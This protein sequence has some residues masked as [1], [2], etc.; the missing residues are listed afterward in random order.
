M[1]D[2]MY[3]MNYPSSLGMGSNSFSAL[4]SETD[5]RRIIQDEVTRMKE[6]KPFCDRYTG[7]WYNEKFCDSDDMAE[8]EED[9]LRKR[10][11]SCSTYTGANDL[12]QI[13]EGAEI[14]VSEI[15]L[16]NT[17][18]HIWNE[19]MY[20]HDIIAGDTTFTRYI[21]DAP[22]LSNVG[23]LGYGRY[24]EFVRYDM[25]RV[26]ENS[27]FINDKKTMFENLRNRYERIES[28][29]DGTY[30]PDGKTYFDDVVECDLKE[31]YKIYIKEWFFLREKFSSP[32]ICDDTYIEHLYTHSPNEFLKREMKNDLKEMKN[33]DFR[34]LVYEYADTMRCVG[35]FRSGNNTQ[36]GFFRYDELFKKG[37]NISF[38]PAMYTSSRETSRVS[39]YVNVC[40]VFDEVFGVS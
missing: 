3:L 22:E 2:K 19:Y 40:C 9:V 12:I 4:I 8:I 39:R 25:K 36:P 38:L 34:E 27:Y 17:I 35:L 32:I 31:E 37:E 7:T 20:Y 16:N 10:I 30:I 33:I 28:K 21:I 18:Y 13:S 24:H 1:K 6:G 29:L 11:T 5:V 14:R 26:L 15:K 23:V